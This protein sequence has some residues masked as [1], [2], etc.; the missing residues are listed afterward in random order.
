MVIFSL[1]SVKT[2]TC[3]RL[4][5]VVG[6]SPVVGTADITFTF[7]NFYMGDFEMEMKKIEY[8]ILNYIMNTDLS[9]SRDL[10][11]HIK[12]V[13]NRYL[14]HSEFTAEVTKLIR[15]GLVRI[16]KMQGTT[17]YGMKSFTPHKRYEVIL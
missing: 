4:V 11:S 8:V 9:T 2:Y 1:F 10:R 6:N 13:T 15:S 17:F 12:D 5:V 3:D 7:F 14:S 16:F